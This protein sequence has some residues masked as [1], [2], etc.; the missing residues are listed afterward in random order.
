M[1]TAISNIAEN[2]SD[3]ILMY[4]KKKK[5]SIYRTNLDIYPL[6]NVL[7]MRF[8]S[9]LGARVGGHKMGIRYRGE[10]YVSFF[11]GGRAAIYWMV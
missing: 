4:A 6:K 5:V 8:M 11:W 3:V 7:K 9:F 1:E 10:P 2:Q